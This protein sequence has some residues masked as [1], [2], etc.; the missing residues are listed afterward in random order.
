MAAGFEGAGRQLRMMGREI[1]QIGSAMVL[2]GTAITAPMLLAY[3]TAA[4][5]SPQIKAQIDG[6]TEQ[7]DKMAISVGTSMLPVMQNFTNVV[8]ALND[9]WNNLSQTQRDH[10]VQT[11]LVAGEYLLFGGIVVKSFGEALRVGGDLLLLTGKLFQGIQTVIAGFRAFGAAAAIIAGVSVPVW[12]IVA[13]C[14]AI[15]AAVAL[16]PNGWKYVADAVQKVW[17][18][19][20]G[21]TLEIKLMWDNLT[22]NSK[23]AAAVVAEQNK[24]AAD[25]LTF[26]PGQHG[27]LAGNIQNISVTMGNAFNTI[28]EGAKQM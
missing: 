12:G 3:K 26:K 9:Q 25:I 17:D 15:V 18:F 24:L 28:K 8:K 23:D 21:V 10:L 5:Y 2:A 14:A 13:A 19:T 6:M 22:R 1:G 16:I 27:D 20:K 11:T 4:Q 7:W